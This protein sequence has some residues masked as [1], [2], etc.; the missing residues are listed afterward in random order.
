MYSQSCKGEK[1]AGKLLSVNVHA[2][3]ETA[4]SFIS[5]LVYMCSV[6]FL[7]KPEPHTCCVAH[8]RCS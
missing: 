7:R 6:S 3:V 4:H 1:L 8:T 2:S 5:A